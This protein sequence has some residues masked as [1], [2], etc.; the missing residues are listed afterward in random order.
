MAITTTGLLPAPVQQRFDLKLLSRPMPSLIHKTFAMK[1]RLTER[2]GQILRLRRYNT[3][4]TA[5]VPLGN[6]GID[7]P[8]ETLSAIDIDARVEWYGKYVIL[9]DQVSLINEDPVLNEAASVL[10]QSLRETE[11]ELTRNMLAATAAFIN[12]TGGVNG[13]FVAVVKSSLI[14]L[15]LLAA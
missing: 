1:K 10:A 3:L 4:Q 9:T 2:S 15:E 13:R 11:D 8:A 7:P 5:T 14:D 12:C 6:T